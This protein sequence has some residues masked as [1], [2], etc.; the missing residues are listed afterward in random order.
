MLRPFADTAAMV[1]ASKVPLLEV[2]EVVVVRV[3]EA[4][5][6]VTAWVVVS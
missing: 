3:P 4:A 5:I 6:A 2:V 1:L